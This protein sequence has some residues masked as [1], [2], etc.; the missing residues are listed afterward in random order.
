[1][2]L[3]DLA[4]LFAKEGKPISEMMVIRCLH[5]DETKRIATIDAIEAISQH[6]GIPSCVVIAENMTEALAIHGALALRRADADRARLTSGLP[7]R[8]NHGT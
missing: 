5:E 2:T 1:M 3:K 6:F 4:A 7:K 8:K